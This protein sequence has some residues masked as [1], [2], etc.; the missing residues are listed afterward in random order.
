MTNQSETAYFRQQGNAM[1]PALYLSTLIAS[2]GL[3]ACAT[4]PVTEVSDA[5]YNR[6]VVTPP[7]AGDAY[8]IAAHD[9]VAARKEIRKPGEA[10]NVILF[11]GDGM[12]ISTITAG[13][14]YAG[15]KLGLDGESY[16]LSM[17]TFPSVALS[18]T[19]AHDGQI[20]D[21]AATATAIVA[22]AKVNVRTLGLTKEGPFGSCLNSKGAEV[23][24]VFEMA[25]ADGLA[26]GI[27]STARITHATPASTYAKSASRDWEDDTEIGAQKEAGCEDIAAQ[28][29]D[30]PAGDGFEVALGGG[31][32][33]FMTK[34]MADPEY[35]GRTGVR[36][37]GRDL[38][39]EWTAKSDDHVYIYD[40]AGFDATDFAGPSKVLGLF[41][42]SHM[43]FELDRAEDKAGEPSLAELTK[44]AITRLSQDED[45]YVLMVEG[46][47]VDHGHHAGNAKRALEDVVSLDAAIK[48]ALEMTSSEDTL[49]LVTADHS[50]VFTIAGYAA[51]GNPI[52][53]KSAYG[54]G[55]YAKGADGKPY[56]TLGYQNGPGAVCHQEDGGVNCERPDLTDVDTEADDY[57]QQSL[58]PMSSETHGGEDVAI[59]ATGPGSEL[60]GGVMEE[61]EI[62]H[63]MTQ[64][65][66]LTK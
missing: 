63:V 50:H 24:T 11:I 27:V 32:S 22:G 23:E 60:V 47:R 35:E 25:E 18:K 62:F 41:E 61:N 42:P 43:Q 21:S 29:I 7:Q 54:T 30:W 17:E 34:D 58:I 40:Q 2:L 15:Q 10:K 52:L 46:G 14:I 53:G 39:G 26:T 1:K 20:S 64:S 56:T 4:S 5:G 37:D 12:G 57:L 13:R 9:A 66:G 3:A 38:I 48:A 59:F 51:R 28:L 19:Y 31:R 49:I 8:Y 55:A 36:E 45:G 33:R 65:L 44:A 6:T 16:R